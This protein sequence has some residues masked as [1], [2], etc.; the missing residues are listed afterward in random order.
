MLLRD[1]I[2]QTL[3]DYNVRVN[4]AI[5]PLTREEMGWKP[6]PEANS[7]AFIYWHVARVEDG[8]TNVFAKGEASLWQRE[9][10]GEKLGLSALGSGFGYSA[11][12]VANFPNLPKDLLQVYF[13][14]V[15]K[16]TLEFLLEI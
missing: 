10:W 15:R 2:E 16:E 13:A 3:E 4:A 7:I 9:R 8:W 5:E 12:Q 1:F 14:S 6:D 11:E